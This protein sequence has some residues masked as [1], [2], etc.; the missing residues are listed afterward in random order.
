MV[1]P[2]LEQVVIDDEDGL[3]VFHGRGLILD[4][5]PVILRRHAKDRRLAADC[6]V[7]TA[8]I[9]GHD[10]RSVEVATRNDPPFD[11]WR[12]QGF[13]GRYITAI[14]GFD[15]SLH[16]SLVAGAGLR[17]L[18]QRLSCEP[19]NRRGEAGLQQLSP[20]RIHGFPP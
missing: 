18:G 17:R 3:A 1:V 13:D 9:D 4:R 2:H 15:V 19:E 20:V 14:G 16:Q 12:H 7:E 11:F 6:L 8:T 10:R 5:D